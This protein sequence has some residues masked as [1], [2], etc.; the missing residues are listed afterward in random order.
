[1]S[2]QKWI[3]ES[4]GSR[5][6]RFVNNSGVAA[7]RIGLESVDHP[8]A[9]LDFPNGPVAAGESFEIRIHAPVLKVR[10]SWS[11]PDHRPGSQ[12]IDL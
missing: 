7:T 11:D 2:D 10:V 4:L 3:I 5:R 8:A 1:M 9:N 6:F 12:V